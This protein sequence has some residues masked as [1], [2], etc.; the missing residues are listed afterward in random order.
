V[1]AHDQ[2]AVSQ[3]APRSVIGL[4]R[5]SR[6]GRLAHQRARWWAGLALCGLASMALGSARAAERPAEEA[7]RAAGDSE[8]P[9]ATFSIVAYDPVRKEWGVAVQSKYFGV[10]T[11]VPWARAG[12]GALA[13]Q[14]YAN[15]SYGPKGLDLL[16]E[17]LSAS[18][19][20]ARLTGE[21]AER[22]RRQLGVVDAQGRAASFTGAECNRW[23]G[24]LT[25]TNFCVQG[26]I[27]AGEGVVKAMAEAFEKARAARKGGL[28]DWLVGV[29][30]AGQD[31][32]GDTRGEQSAALLVVREKGGHGGAHD[33]FI[34]LRVD[35]HAR[36]IQELARLLE[37]HRKFYPR[38]HRQ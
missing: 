3:G 9:V 13:T 7:R 19:V 30:Q 21:D 33:R 2:G 15:V 18:E 37:I 24:H 5:E 28:A 10:G 14:S 20:V 26:N 8:D 23:A 17:G 27:L 25:G 12:A 34:D 1:K 31:A 4:S 11:V 35:D 6:A 29:L 22:E 38:A 32:G 36:P 16:E